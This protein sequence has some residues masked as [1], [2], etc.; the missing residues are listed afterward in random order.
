MRRAANMVSASIKP[1]LSSVRTWATK[2]A[3]GKYRVLVR[4][5]ISC[6]VLLD[7]KTPSEVL[8]ADPKPISKTGKTEFGRSRY[9]HGHPLADENTRLVPCA[10][11]S[12]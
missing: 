4:S 11:T 10:R 2:S 8:G 1:E 6:H 7:D 9:V 12:T 5:F 3:R